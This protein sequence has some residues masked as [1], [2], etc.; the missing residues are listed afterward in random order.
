MNLKELIS[1]ARG[2]IPAGLLLKNAHIV[3]TFIGEIE[4]IKCLLSLNK[5][6]S[7]F[8]KTF[9]VLCQKGA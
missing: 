9:S 5:F 2:E 6:M 8:C 1:V 4:H 7:Q 3:N